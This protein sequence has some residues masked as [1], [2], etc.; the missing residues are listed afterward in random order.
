MCFPTFNYTK[1][2]KK[3]KCDRT[4]RP[5]DRQTDTVTYRVACKRLKRNQLGARSPELNNEKAGLGISL[6][7]SLSDRLRKSSSLSTSSSSSSSSS[8]TITSIFLLRRNT[9]VDYSY[10][11]KSYAKQTNA[12]VNNLKKTLSYFLA[13]A[14]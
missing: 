5:T 8:S 1:K 9:K 6:F 4:D 11:V 7:L 12:T 13:A 10:Q 2:R 3:A 14:I